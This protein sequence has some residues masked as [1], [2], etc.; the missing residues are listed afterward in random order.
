MSVDGVNVRQRVLDYLANDR[1]MKP[2][3]ISGTSR[4]QDDLGLDGDDAAEFFDWIADQFGTDL[5]HLQKK[6][7][8]YFS[9]ESISF[10]MIGIMTVSVLAGGAIAMATDL[11]GLWRILPMAAV[12]CIGHWCYLHWFPLKAITVDEVVAAIE[13]GAWNDA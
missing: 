1:L 2:D 7:R 9:S 3:R 4:L 8:A 10:G 5:S 12:M 6:W 11:S 13:R